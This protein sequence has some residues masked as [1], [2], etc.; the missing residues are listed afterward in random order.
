VG[1]LHLSFSFQEKWVFCIFQFPGNVP[2]LECC[3]PSIR[4]A[5]RKVDV[6]VPFNPPTTGRSLVRPGAA[7]FPKL[8]IRTLL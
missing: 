8:Y 4:A 7:S 6:E 5:V 1:I 3:S 2:S